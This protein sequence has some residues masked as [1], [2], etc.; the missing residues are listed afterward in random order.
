MLWGDQRHA[1]E[2]DAEVYSFEFKSLQADTVTVDK[3]D[4]KQ[5]LLWDCFRE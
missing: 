5:M 2:N 1:I 4:W 3:I